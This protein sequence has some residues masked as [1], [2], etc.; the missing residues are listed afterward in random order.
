MVSRNSLIDELETSIATGTEQKRSTTLRRVTDLFVYRAA[1]LSEEQV[2]VF[3]DVIGR[4]A[5]RMEF[6]ARAELSRRL[7]PIDNAP[8]ESV[9][10]L[11]RDEEVY[12]AGPVLTASARLKDQDLIDAAKAK[13]QS[14]LQAISQREELSESVTAVL[15]ERGDRDVVRSVAQNE[16]AR[17]SDA[18]YGVLVKK[19]VGDDV[20]GEILGLRMDLPPQHLRALVQKASEAVKKKL[21][22]AGAGSHPHLNQVLAELASQMQEQAAPT[23]RPQA[24]ADTAVGTTL[25]PGDL[26][27]RAIENLA[28]AG[29]FVDLTAALA[30]MCRLPIGDIVLAMK[31]GDKDLILTLLRSSG[32]SWTTAKAILLM[33]RSGHSSSLQDLA[34]AEKQFE[35]LQIAI[36][37]KVV[38][39]NLTRL[40]NAAGD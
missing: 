39:F 32:V 3:D 8:I 26:Q 10:A 4:L 31:S 16:G 37:Q 17:F 18:G 11:A 12:I 34:K 19:S 35:R 25:K 21:A 7:A 24:A 27:D 5:K 1:D 2:G 23:V 30:A 9:R 28:R 15:V 33:P 22:A 13:S 36:A 14:H 6:K 29:R 40:K 38:R 20:L